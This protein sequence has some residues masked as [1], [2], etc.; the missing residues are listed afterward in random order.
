MLYNAVGFL[1]MNFIVRSILCIDT[2]DKFPFI[3]TYNIITTITAVIATTLNTYKPGYY[4]PITPLCYICSDADTTQYMHHSQHNTGTRI[5][6]PVY[7]YRY[8][9]TATCIS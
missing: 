6:I 5:S 1:H 7:Q 3:H 9:Y 8:M 2:T 4:K